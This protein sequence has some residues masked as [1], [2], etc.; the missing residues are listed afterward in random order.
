MIC[1]VRRFPPFFSLFGLPLADHVA[2]LPERYL[3][4]DLYHHRLDHC[5]QRYNEYHLVLDSLLASD[6]EP[7]RVIAAP[8]LKDEVL[9]PLVSRVN[10]AKTI[11]HRIVPTQ[12]QFNDAACKLSC[13]Y[14][15]AGVRF[16]EVMMLAEKIKD[17]PDLYL[18]VARAFFEP[19]GDHVYVTSQRKRTR[20]PAFKVNPS[21]KT[22]IKLDL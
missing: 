2:T 5:R 20:A 10:E 14:I 11:L 22:Q 18:R 15:W 3:P 16:D 13:A 12:G 9:D 17:S 7:L 8:K 19:E 21:P 4:E 6:I 1:Q